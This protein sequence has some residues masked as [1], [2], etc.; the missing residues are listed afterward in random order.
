MLYID[1]RVLS[2]YSWHTCKSGLLRFWIVTQSSRS[3]RASY[4]FGS[5]RN[6]L[7]AK[8]PPTLLDRHAILSE[9]KNVS[10]RRRLSDSL[11]CRRIFGKQT[12]STSSRNVWSLSWI[13]K[14][15]EGWGE[16]GKLSLVYNYANLHSQIIRLHCRL[17]RRCCANS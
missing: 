5:S 15:E 13:L 2:T 10:M 8:E 12:L 14:A 6:P 3:Q 16:I 7:G 1:R 11:Q 4:A 17:A 9:P